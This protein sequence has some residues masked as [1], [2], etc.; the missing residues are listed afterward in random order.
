[1]A[2][3]T[4][5]K[6]WIINWQLGRRNLTPYVR[7]TLALRLADELKVKARENLKS[8]GIAT[9]ENLVQYRGLPT[10][11]NPGGDETNGTADPRADRLTEA[12]FSRE[13]AGG[14]QA[15]YCRCCGRKSFCSRSSPMLAENVAE[16]NGTADPSKRGG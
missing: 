9:R 15:G 12:D 6:I 5:A 13:K 11:A 10:L 2:I 7:S 14:E 1:L 16:T 8:G 4:D 3:S